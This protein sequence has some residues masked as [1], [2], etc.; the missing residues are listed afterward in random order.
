MAL[1]SRSTSGKGQVIDLALL[2]AMTSV[3]GPEALDYQLL[4]KPKPRV[5]NG[6]NTSSPRNVYQ[7]SDGGFIALSAS[8]QKTAERVFRCIGREDLITHPDFC[9]NEHRVA[10][11]H[12]VDQIVGGMGSVSGR[13]KRASPY[14]MSTVFTAAPV[15]D[16]EDITKDQHFQGAWHLCRTPG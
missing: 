1:R 7:T 9:T 12:A 2:D 16:I 15:Y 3:L 14:S 10:R 4:Q 8:M 11:R 13:W 5:G 6:S